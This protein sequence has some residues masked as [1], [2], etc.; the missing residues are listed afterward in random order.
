MR[1]QCEVHGVPVRAVRRGARPNKRFVPAFR[2]NT[3]DDT[4]HIL[5]S[6][7]RGDVK[8][9]EG[10]RTRLVADSQPAVA[11][12]GA[13]T[14]TRQRTARDARDARDARGA[15]ADAFG[16][17]GV[18]GGAVRLPGRIRSTPSH[19]PRRKRYIIMSDL[20]ICSSCGFSNYILES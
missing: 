7:K 5:T 2:E 16:G 10:G 4:H 20:V 13:L 8:T 12:G 6:A 19:F 17:F 9:H 15:P 11:T 1:V 3:R 14:S 18:F